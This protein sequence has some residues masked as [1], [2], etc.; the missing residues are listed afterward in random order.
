LHSSLS[1]AFIKDDSHI[2]FIDL[3]VIFSGKDYCILVGM[4][5]KFFPAGILKG[6]LP[7]STTALD[8]T[9]G[10][11]RGLTETIV[12]DVTHHDRHCIVGTLKRPAGKE[13]LIPRE[14]DTQAVV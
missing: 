6:R 3:F 5:Q 7:Y 11:P 10:S 9:F 4:T 14:N 2:H 13:S 12:V 1:P 8:A